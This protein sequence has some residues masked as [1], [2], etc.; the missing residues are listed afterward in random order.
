[1]DD[2]DIKTAITRS[3]DSSSG[4]YDSCPGHQ[5]GT[6]AEEEAWMHELRVGIPPPPMKILDVGCGTGAMGL[7]F[8]KMGYDVFGVDLSL[9]MMN[10]ARMKATNQNLKLELQKGDAEDLPF[11][12]ESFDVIVN[13]HLLWTLPNPDTA[14]LEWYRVLKPGGTLLV[15]DG[16]W[17][18]KRLSSRLKR[19]VSEGLTRFF[20]RNE[21]HRHGYDKN[22]RKSLPHDGGVSQEKMQQYLKE[23]GYNNASFRD[24][25]Y[26]RAL[27]RERMAWYRKI[28]TGKS[29]YILQAKK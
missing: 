23:S 12:D 22:L 18:D 28:T 26:I 11:P 21:T 14:L 24:L 6:K 27:Q 9:A 5:I 10:Q 1:M 17:N 15:I 2:G 20:E 29:Y 4:M 19:R 13:R 7:L 25:M 3:W 8:A 16:V